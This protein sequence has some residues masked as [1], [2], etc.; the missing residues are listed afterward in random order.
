LKLLD[1]FSLPYYTPNKT[2]LQAQF[3]PNIEKETK[4]P[5]CKNDEHS[6]KTGAIWD[7]S[8]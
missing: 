3:L 4:S 7:R 5:L 1:F 6:Q 2:Q 8:C